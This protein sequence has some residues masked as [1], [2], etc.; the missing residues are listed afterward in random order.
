MLSEELPKTLEPLKLC[1][2]G[3]VTPVLMKGSMDIGSNLDLGTETEPIESHG[4][5]NKAIVVQAEL[6][7]GMDVDG[8]ATVSGS[9]AGEVEL[10]CQRCL[11]R[12]QYPIQTSFNL[13]PV[14]SLSE[15]A[16]LPERYEPL[17]LQPEG[18]LNIGDFLAEEVHLALPIVPRHE[19]SECKVKI[20]EASTEDVNEKGKGEER[21]HHPFK[22]LNELIKKK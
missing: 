21:T 7:F 19:P 20:P 11:E 14:V 10:R 22:N 16:K 1:Q 2:K 6:I 15:S 13:S 12:M 9:V 17:M 8:Y 18:L 3:K 4:E 5:K